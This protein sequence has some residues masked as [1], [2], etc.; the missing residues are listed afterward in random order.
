MAFKDVRFNLV[1]FLKLF[2]HKKK[3]KRGNV[4]ESDRRS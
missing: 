3:G 1:F 2:S 4:Q